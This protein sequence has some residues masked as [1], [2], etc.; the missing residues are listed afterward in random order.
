M[1][2]PKT[3]IH[4]RDPTPD[5]TNLTIQFDAEEFVHHLREYDL[6]DDEKI[7]YLQT[8]WSIVLQFVDLGFGL[9]PIQQACGQKENSDLVCGIADSDALYLPHSTLCE[10]FTSAGTCPCSPRIPVTEGERAS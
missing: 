6:S 10:D 9:H 5:K 8:I 4:E 2:P 1:K 3:L 7:E